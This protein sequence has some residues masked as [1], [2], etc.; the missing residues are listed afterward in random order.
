VEKGKRLKKEHGRTIKK[1]GLTIWKD[2]IVV[3]IRPMGGGG[4]GGDTVIEQ[5]PT[6]KKTCSP[7]RGQVFRRIGEDPRK[8]SPR[9]SG[10]GG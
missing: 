10:K 6:Q 7:Q 8:S 3:G 4:G 2:D 9:N 1:E 5:K